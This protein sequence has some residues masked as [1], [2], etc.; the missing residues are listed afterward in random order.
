MISFLQSCKDKGL[1]TL[2]QDDGKV[3]QTITQPDVH[4]VETLSGNGCSCVPPL[5]VLIRDPL[6]P[7]NVP[8]PVL[9]S[10]PLIGW[11]GRKLRSHDQLVQSQSALHRHLISVEFNRKTSDLPVAAKKT[12][13]G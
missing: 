13:T 6:Q 4:L 5:Q 8:Q 12:K 11:W 7:S 9:V 2:F 3:S 10:G 1:T